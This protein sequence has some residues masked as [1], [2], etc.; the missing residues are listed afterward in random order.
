MDVQRGRKDRGRSG[1]DRNIYLWVFISTPCFQARSSVSCVRTASS[2]GILPTH[3]ACPESGRVFIKDVCI[4]NDSFTVP[5]HLS[6]SVCLP[7]V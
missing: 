6:G 4:H 5:A 1:D 7:A 3:L 2:G